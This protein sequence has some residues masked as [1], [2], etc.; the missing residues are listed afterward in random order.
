MS[1]A[2]ALSPSAIATASWRRVQGTL[3]AVVLAGVLTLI[4]PLMVHAQQQSGAGNTF[5]SQELVDSGHVFFG[6]M[7]RGMADVVESLTAQYGQPN[8]YILGEEASAAFFG[9]LRYGEGVLY[10]RNAGNHRVYWQGPSIGFDMGGDGTRTMI[11]VYNL[12]SVDTMYQ[13]FP[14]V[15]GSA[16]LVGGLSASANQSAQVVVA[17]IR[18]GIGARLGINVG[19]LKFTRQPTWNPF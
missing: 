19:Y 11:L 14:G 18:A 5:S 3:L 7:A 10:T 12:P 8:G 1:L 17:P 16:F 4:S 15:S 2:F 9:G 13:R 6:N